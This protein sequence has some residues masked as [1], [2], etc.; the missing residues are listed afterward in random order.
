MN[1]RAK[2]SFLQNGSGPNEPCGYR[3]ACIELRKTPNRNTK[4]RLSS[5]LQACF[6]TRKMPNGKTKCKIRS[7]EYGITNIKHWFSTYYKNTLR[8]AYLRQI[9]ASWKT[10]VQIDVQIV[11][12]FEKR[13]PP[14]GHQISILV[15]NNILPFPLFRS[16]GRLGIIWPIWDYIQERVGVQRRGGAAVEAF[17]RPIKGWRI[18]F[19]P[20]NIQLFAKNCFYIGEKW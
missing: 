5:C 3:Q 19:Q 13:N 9:F 2:T 18:R 12:Y 15:N 8:I 4:D 1:Q 6:A 20:I 10:N 14:I 11:A 16:N 7:A 17:A